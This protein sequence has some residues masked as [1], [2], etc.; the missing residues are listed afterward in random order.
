ML[1]LTDVLNIERKYENINVIKAFLQEPR[2]HIEYQAAFFV[3]LDILAGLKYYEELYQT[4]KNQVKDF[5]NQPKTDY[6]ENILKIMFDASLKLEY[7]SDAKYY[8]DVRK[9]VV[10]LKNEYD[11]SYDEIKYKKALNM[12]YEEDIERLLTLEIKEGLK[13][14]LLIELY[15]LKKAKSLYEDTYKI[16]KNLEKYDLDE[17]LRKEHLITLLNLK[18]YKQALEKANYYI[19]RY[20]NDTFPLYALISSH[21]ELDELYK[22]VRIEADYEEFIEKQNDEYKEMMYELFIDLYEK[23]NNKLSINL[24]KDKLKKLKSKPKLKPEEKAVKLTEKEVIIEKVK[25]NSLLY[26]EFTS[27]LINDVKNADPLLSLRD[28]FRLIF[29]EVEKVI[30]FFEVLIYINREQSNLFHYKVERLYDKR[31]LPSDLEH[32]YILDVYNQKLEITDKLFNLKSQKN[33]INQKEY[34]E[35]MY[36]Y[37]FYLD[38]EGVMSFHFKENIIDPSSYY[39]ILNVIKELIDYK[40]TQ[41]N[42]LKKLKMT[43]N[44]YDKLLKGPLLAYR[45]MDENV[46][47]YND[48][49]KTMLGLETYTHFETFLQ[50]ISYDHI[51]EYEKIIKELF[52]KV[53]L[54]KEITYTYLNKTIKEKLYSIKRMDETIIMSVFEDNTDLVNETKTL[55]KEATLDEETHLLNKNMLK[56]ALP[57]ILKDKAAFLLID[58]Y[59]EIKTI[60]GYDEYQ[61]FFKEFA[62]ITKKFFKDGTTYR[63]EFNKLLVILNINDIRSVTN[64]TKDY[65]NYLENYNSQV[66]KFE[67]FKTTIGILRYPVVTVERNLDK[68]LRYLHIG[69]E[70]AKRNSEN[71]SF[72]SFKDYETEV[73]EQEIINHLNLAIENKTFILNFKQITDIRKNLIWQ[74]ESDLKI[75]NL[76]VDG[77]YI[78]YVAK[79]R[80]RIYAL[81]LHHIELVLAFLLKLEEETERLIKV[82]IPISKD[83]FLQPN[84]NQEL[85]ELIKKY[86]IP[87]EFISLKL[88]FD[89]RPN[90]YVQKLKELTDFGLTIHTTS[91]DLALNYEINYLHQDYRPDNLKWQTFLDYINKLMESNKHGFVVRNVKTK[92]EREKLAKLNVAYIEGPIYIEIK[93]ID[94]ISKIKESL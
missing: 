14:E 51:K 49:A 20:K 45:E 37:S 62:Q 31:V 54:K 32:T 63:I 29:I 36:V 92:L 53:G 38:N 71:Y 21:I 27:K 41:E 61:M 34:V 76:A 48:E 33:I 82:L 58:F 59:D 93:D 90:Y 84:F 11:L 24:Y 79:K 25:T 64:I 57:E 56:N 4:G 68:L 91:L 9:N 10:S 52:Q 2:S 15:Y 46:S 42:V 18:D 16:I 3:I 12:D 1:R 13:K 78:S 28:F 89:L 85:I 81:E 88:D 75:P 39:D 8:L 5:L 65:I 87:N 22:A 70:K 44:F 17:T 60:Y 40:L 47:I 74:Y 67:K 26:L 35:N 19:R 7:F 94:L 77:K 66:L 30:K 69:V 50:N 86:Q 23:L 72:F 55:V 43:N 73:F 80:N 6:L 83:T